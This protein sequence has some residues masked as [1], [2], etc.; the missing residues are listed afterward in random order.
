MEQRNSPYGIDFPEIDIKKIEN[1]FDQKLKTSIQST[2]KKAI[3]DVRSEIEEEYY[4]KYSDNLEHYLNDL[5]LQ[6]ARALVVGLLEGDEDCL[7]HFID[8]GYSRKQI[9]ESVVDYTA[10]KE[11]E[12]LRK[13]NE[14]LSDNLKYYQTNRF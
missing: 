12:E 11:I 7:K 6:K 8:F 2:L 14:R 1:D 4:S 5:V 9:L 3:E 13:D 10:K